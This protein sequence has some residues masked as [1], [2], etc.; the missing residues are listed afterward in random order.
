MFF[1]TL[2]FVTQIADML[3]HITFDKHSNIQ[4]IGEEKASNL[5]NET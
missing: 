1:Q 5:G 4:I 2:Y 3:K